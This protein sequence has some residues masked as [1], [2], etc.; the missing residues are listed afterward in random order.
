MLF[1]SL[2]L[3]PVWPGLVLAALGSAIGA[4]ALTYAPRDAMRVALPIVI[5]A[6]ALYFALS[7]RLSDAASR[8]RLKRPAFV[9]TVVPLVGF[10]DGVFGPGAGSFYMLGFV[11]LL[12]LGIVAATAETKAVNFASNIAGLATLAF[13][14]QI[15]WVVGFLMGAAQIAGASLGAR[16]AIRTGARLIK[17]LVVGVSLLLA[18]KLAADAVK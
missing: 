4:S 7:P 16:A 5:G 3:G 15:F 17:P 1:R 10:Y 6:V 12:G 9:A 18:L 8:P 14:G 11:A 2:R 13:S